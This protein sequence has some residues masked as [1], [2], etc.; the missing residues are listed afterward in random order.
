MRELVAKIEDLII[1]YIPTTNI[2]TDGLTKLL[3]P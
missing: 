2:L 3:G 1:G